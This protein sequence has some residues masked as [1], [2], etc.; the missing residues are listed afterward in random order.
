MGLEHYHQK[1]N[2]NKTREPK[3]K[4]HD[5][6]H[7]R[8]YVQK[9]AASH[10]HYD[11]RLELNGVLKSWAIPKGPSL[12]FHIKRLAMQVED[13]PIEYGL[14]EGIIPKGE[15]GGGTVMLWD[16]G[17]WHSLDK[18]PLL[19]YQKGH[20]RFELHAE[21]L[22]GRWDL[23][24]SSK[25][26]H[27]WFLIKHQD[28]FSTDEDITQCCPNS[29]VSNLSIDQISGNYQEIW[30][31]NGLVKQKKEIN[32][33]DLPSQPLPTKISPQL[34][35]LVNSPPKGDE[36]LHEIK[37]DGY[38][39]LAFKNKND[40]KLMSRNNKDWTIEFSN[41]ANFIAKLPV[42]NV[43]LDGEI[44][45]LDEQGR[46]NFQLLQNV[47]STKDQQDLIFYGF[48]LLYYDQWDLRNLPL[49]E[50]KK[51]LQNLLKGAEPSI[52]FS[53]HT[54][55]QGER[56][57][58]HA[59]KFALEG[60]VS[61]KIDSHYMTKRSKTWLKTKCM[62]RQE[63]VIGGFS[64][65]KHSREGFGALFLG[66]YNSQQDLIYS[67]KV[68]TGFTK[69]SLNDL[70]M[71]LKKIIA[72][73]NPFS[74]SPPGKTTA[75]WVI[76]K[77]VAEIEF[78]EWTKE[79]RLRHPSFCGLRVDKKSKDVRKE[80]AEPVQK[81]E[82]NRPRPK[83]SVQQPL[84]HPHKILYQEDGITKHD[85]Y[86]Y[87]QE[88]SPYILPYLTKRLL[89]LVRCP[90]QYNDCFY[91]KKIN[92]NTTKNL[93]TMDVLNND[94]TKH[95][96]Y[97][98]I[99]NEAG[100]LSLVQMGVLEIHPW[101]SRI[102]AIE[103]P[104]VIIMDL[105]P[106]PDVAWKRVVAAAFDVKHY[107]ELLGLTTFV[108]TTGGKGLHVV[109]PIEPEYCWVDIKNFTEN[110]VH[111]L[112][113]IKPNEYIGIMSKGMRKGKIFIDYLRNQR[114][115]TAI[116]PYSTRARIHAPIAVPIDWQE[117]TNNPADTYYTLKTLPQ[118]LHHFKDPWAD[119]GKIKQS[120][121]LNKLNG[122]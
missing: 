10:L 1:R 116:A 72:A 2:F 24:Q 62:K 111:T 57:L 58:K 43:V 9:H 56:I 77:L 17:T 71:D 114:G 79:G 52:R 34:A 118:R 90:V 46:S 16:K 115:A 29:V 30:T 49:I 55:G 59:C 28:E 18:E 99:E 60:I 3:G 117:L 109:I 73:E 87:Y 39:V 40:V 14:F 122:I 94:A 4:M 22:H 89:T 25:D 47:I 27:A 107:F 80:I 95:N 32:P 44:V 119:F 7:H 66:F 61:K 76:P 5:E 41:L 106:A 65:P 100:L 54:I 82:E 93:Q 81:I 75:T 42:S 50:R 120:L 68:G 102:E 74:S 83:R 20:L 97:I 98:Y 91:Q 104:D 11:F 35:T 67:G 8:F 15:Y 21:K 31:K 37:L 33:L 112:Q 51:M 101:G 12:D 19:A 64:P 105:D 78:S 26:K 48:D 86:H 121:H 70:Y 113:T 96:N 69:Q 38:R 84:T 108:K 45:L 88:I 92:K 53:D 36:W 63:F 13:H 6:D 110:F 85:L 103:N 23:V